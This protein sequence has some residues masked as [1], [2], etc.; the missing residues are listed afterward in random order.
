DM[1]ITTPDYIYIIELKFKHDS[2]I[3]ADQIEE[4]GYDLPY[5]ADRRKL[6]KIGVNFSAESRHLDKPVIKER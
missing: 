2:S 4:K 1:V 3:A 5:A 6:F